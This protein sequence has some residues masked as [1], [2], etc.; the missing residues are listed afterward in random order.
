M[1]DE[2]DARIWNEHGQQFSEDLHR[3]LK[4]V[5]VSLKRLHAIQ[6]DAPWRKTR[7]F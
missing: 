3:L 4:T 1:R 7:S 5:A 2:I 6:F